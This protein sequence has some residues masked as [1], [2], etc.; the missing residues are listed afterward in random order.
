MLKSDRTVARVIGPLSVA[1]LGLTINGAPLPTTGI[2]TS[3]AGNDSTIAPLEW[4]DDSSS[5]CSPGFRR[6]SS[7]RRYSFSPL[8]AVG[9]SNPPSEQHADATSTLSTAE[10]VA[11]WRFARNIVASGR[12]GVEVINQ[13]TGEKVMVWEGDDVYQ[14]AILLPHATNQMVASAGSEPGDDDHA[15]P[16]LTTTLA[17]DPMDTGVALVEHNAPLTDTLAER[18]TTMKQSELLTN[19]AILD[20]KAQDDAAFEGKPGLKYEIFST[21]AAVNRSSAFN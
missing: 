12:K 17:N 10:A 11:D 14:K 1:A 5:F 19:Y 21:G 3:T 7:G 16:Q 18:L 13:A 20:T 6:V 4:Q 8:Q 9:S 15:D 2:A